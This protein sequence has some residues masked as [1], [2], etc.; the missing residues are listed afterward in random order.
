MKTLMKPKRLAKGDTIATVSPCNGWAGDM[1]TRWVY[2][3][4]IS[5]LREIGLQVVAAPNSM[6]GSDYL[7]KNPKARAED[8][9]W[10]FENDAV[11]AVIANVCGNDSIKVIPYIDTKAIL[12]HP[13]IFIGYSDVMNIHLLC[14]RCGLSSF[15]GSNLFHPIADQSGW[16]RYSKKWFL[17]TLFDTQAIGQIEPSPDWTFEPLDYLH[18]ETKRKYYPNDGYALI[19]GTGTVTGRLIGGHTGIMELE[20]SSIAL[21]PEDYDGAILFVEDIPEFFDETAVSIFFHYLGENGI[22]Q[23]LNG[24][25]IG[26]ANENGSFSRRSQRI[27][28]ITSGTYSCAIPVLYGLNFGHSSPGF[29]LPY[30]A[31]AEINCEEKTFAILESGVSA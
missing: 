29:V 14:Y 15:Y 10:A 13:K 22:L 30:G 12:G 26:K 18:A 16:H 7:S 27:R 5:R 2:D 31:L 20:G 4:G 23:K 11:D 8:I 25:I 19:Q 17:K 28:E 3:L 6:R 21:K 9:T 24:I 1:E